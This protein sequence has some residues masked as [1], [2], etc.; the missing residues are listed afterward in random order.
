ML[1]TASSLRQAHVPQ[2]RMQRAFDCLKQQ[3]GGETPLSSLHVDAVGEHIV[4]HDGDVAWDV[5]TNQFE[6]DFPSERGEIRSLPFNPVSSTTEA[7]HWYRHAME[8]EHTSPDDALIAYQHAVK[9]N[10]EL[11]DAQV[12]L[13]RML[14]ARGRVAEAADHYR[15][16]LA[17]APN[18][19]ASFNLGV[20]LEDL[21]YSTDALEAYRNAIAL[22]P[23]MPDAHYNLAKLY[24]SVGDRVGAIRH[25]KAYRL[26]V[27]G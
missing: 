6:I 27:R 24:E 4:V 17:H 23:S 19:T 20:A 25:L 11:A 18:P 2:L 16:A 10:P 12:N 13:G 15:R 22:N 5:E 8:M 1:R 7:D 9:L 26:I 3:I 21:G 14:H